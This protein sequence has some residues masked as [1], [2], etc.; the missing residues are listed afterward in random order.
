L[1]LVLWALACHR[2]E[3]GAAGGRLSARWTGADTATFS[4][5]AVA[6]WCDSLRL[7]EIR[8]VAGD[9]GVGIALYPPDTLVAGAYPIRPPN[10]ADTILPPSAAVALR[11]FSKTTVM[12]YQGDSGALTLGRRPDGSLSGRFSA[13]ARPLVSGARLR[14]GG[15]FDGL[16]VVR[17]PREC[18][19]NPRSDTTASDTAA[20][21][22]D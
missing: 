8:A 10:V 20:V 5:P 14:V 22:R 9:T 4:A 21:G 16:R 2:D 12:G 15:T 13:A 19:G 1:A 11:W 17:A 7:L 6:E 18:A 3:P